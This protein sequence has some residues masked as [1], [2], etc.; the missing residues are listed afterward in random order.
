MKIKHA[1]SLCV[2]L[3]IAGCASVTS[4]FIKLRPDFS[5]APEEELRA[6]ARAVEQAVARGDRD[7]DLGSFPGVVLDTP[8]IRQAIRA[9]AARSELVSNLLD[10]GFAYEQRNGTIKMINSRAYRRSSNA[11]ERDQNALVVMS[12]NQNRW[13]LYEGIRKESEWAPGT[14]GAVQHSFYEARI[15]LLAPGHHYEDEHGNIVA[16]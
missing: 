2:L 10:T 13:A 11:R 7:P 15:P 9:R 12:E 14:L 4:P 8:E 1:V 5:Q 6:A 16:R 3:V